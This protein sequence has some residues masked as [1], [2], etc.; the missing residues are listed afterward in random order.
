VQRH[1]TIED[2]AFDYDQRG[3]VHHGPRADFGIYSNQNIAP[4]DLFEEFGN[5]HVT[6]I[7]SMDVLSNQRRS[8]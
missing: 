5:P 6:Q 4:P 7:Q 3:D 1:L 8:I 2:S